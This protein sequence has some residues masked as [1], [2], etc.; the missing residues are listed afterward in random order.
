M[1]NAMKNNRNNARF[2]LIACAIGIVAALIGC[3]MTA[4]AGTAM[5]LPTATPDY[6]I[7][8]TNKDGKVTLVADGVKVRVAYWTDETPYFTYSRPASRHKR[9]FKAPDGSV[10]RVG[11][12]PESVRL[13]SAAA[14]G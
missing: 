12:S 7:V 8:C 1:N 13:T 10:C 9:T 4:K 11:A 2:I 6:P 3:V 5:P 14:R